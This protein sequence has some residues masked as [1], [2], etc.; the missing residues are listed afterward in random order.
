MIELLT[1]FLDTEVGRDTKLHSTV[2]KCY[3]YGTLTTN[4]LFS[5][6][7]TVL[8]NYFEQNHCI[9]NLVRK[10]SKLIYAKCHIL[11]ARVLKKVLTDN[12]AQR[13]PSFKNKFPTK[14]V[15]QKSLSFS[16]W[17]LRS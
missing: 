9:L 12:L 3:L 5:Q 11:K 2:E 8:A 7:D 15:G 17:A 4:H 10:I 1:A 16:A 13:R 14:T 6:V